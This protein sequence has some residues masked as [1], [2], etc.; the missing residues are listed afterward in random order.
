MSKNIVKIKLLPLLIYSVFFIILSSRFVETYLISGE[1][2]FW[3]AAS[4]IIGLCFTIRTIL[5]K[6][7]YHNTIFYIFIIYIICQALVISLVDGLEYS[8]ITRLVLFTTSFCMFPLMLSFSYSGAEAVYLCLDRVLIVV[9]AYGW[10]Q[11]IGSL[12]NLP[13][14]IEIFRGRQYGS[15]SQVTSF[16]DEPAFLAHFLIA[17]LYINL[18]VRKKNAHL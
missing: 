16:F 1:W 5:I 9:C 12:L 17:L 13:T 11:F 15:I 6:K 4:L 10:Y 18:C 14:G 7:N 3:F 2:R 8:L